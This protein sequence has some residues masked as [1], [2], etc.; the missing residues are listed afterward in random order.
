MKLSKKWERWYDV[1]IT[2]AKNLNV[3]KLYTMTIK[4]ESLREM[5]NLLS[6][7]TP[8]NYEINEDQ[9]FISHR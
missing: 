5:L 2:L 4:T 8:I 1:D 7:T 9:V 6:Y 3:T